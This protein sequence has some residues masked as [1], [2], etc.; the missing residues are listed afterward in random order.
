MKKIS[1]IFSITI[2][3]T[4][5][6][7]I[8]SFFCPNWFIV[9]TNE[10]LFH[11]L[12][13]CDQVVVGVGGGCQLLHWHCSST[14]LHEHG[15]GTPVVTVGQGTQPVIGPSATKSGFHE[16]KLIFFFSKN[17]FFSVIFF[18]F[19]VFSKIEN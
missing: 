10:H 13:E 7:K 19:C 8:P 1:L 16:K 17:M 18:V 5:T 12:D 6:K 15:G 3:S 14:Y 11:A 2:F 4:L 9:L